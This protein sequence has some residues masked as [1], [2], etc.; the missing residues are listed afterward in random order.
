M[1]NFLN[2]SKAEKY[3][4]S[5]AVLVRLAMLAALIFYFGEDSLYRFP[6]SAGA[7]WINVSDS[8][9]HVL[10]FPDGIRMPGYAF[11]VW[12][13]R[14]LG[15]PIWF[16]SVVQIVL[17]SLMPIMAMRMVRMLGLG[18]RTEI[19]AGILTAFEP[20]QIFYSV[21]IASDPLTALIFFAGV[22]YFV[23]FSIENR[24]YY[25]YLAAFFLAISNYFRPT[26]FYF[27]FMVPIVIFFFWGWI[28]KRWIYA[29]K[30][31]ILFFAIFL[32]I[33]SPWMVRNYIK[34]GVF[35]FGS[36]GAWYL[37][38]FTAGGVTAATEHITF[39]QAQSKLE[40]E[41]RPFIPDTEDYSSIK[42][43]PILIQKA[44]QVV[45]TYPGTFLRMYSFALQTYFFSGNYH[46]ILKH[47]GVVD[48]P[49][50]GIVS[51]TRLFG[52]GSLADVWN[53][54]LIFIQEP[55]GMIALLGRVFLG[56]IFL[57]SLAGALLFFRKERS[58]W[59]PAVIYLFCIAYSALM[60]LTAVEGMEARHRLWL[61]PLIFV[62]ASVGF[63]SLA[64]WIK[65]YW[66]SLSKPY[67]QKIR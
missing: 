60:V 57:S 40:N 4:F 28:Q 29:L 8:L 30:T 18:L 62:F 7:L 12:I 55:Y 63:V 51:F 16:T 46:F 23:Y 58:G 9:Q 13:F 56:A 19:L 6:G 5:G 34:E 36:G 37:F 64:V 59:F 3:I 42:N 11:F 17:Y 25:L 10:S 2:F 52:G 27:L 65:N 31:A 14:A 39:E 50:T 47:Y 33:V 49:S 1:S 20:L 48:P 44:L 43:S 61:N 26:A 32:L 24:L 67:L 66:L 54:M 21:L 53:R 41:V 45:S 15:L 35:S 38:I 22:Y